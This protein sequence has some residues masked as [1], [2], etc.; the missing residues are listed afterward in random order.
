MVFLAQVV[1]AAGWGAYF[2]WSVPALYSGIAGRDLQQLGTTSYM[3][4]AAAGLAG[5]LSTFAW[6]RLAD[7]T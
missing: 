6:W 3:L 4:V 7:Q 5:V 2:P 1:A